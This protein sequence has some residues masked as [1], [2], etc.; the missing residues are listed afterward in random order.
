MLNFNSLLLQKYA[1]LFE[2]ERIGLLELPY[3][4]EDRLHKLGIPLGP[5][6]RILQQAHLANPNTL[7]VL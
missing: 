4:T 2:K 5:R 3:L 7:A 6:L 1:S